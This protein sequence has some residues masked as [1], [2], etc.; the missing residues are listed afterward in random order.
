VAVRVVIATDKFKG[1]ASASQMAEMLA[2]ELEALVPHADVVPLP[3]A[4]GGQGTL[5]ALVGIADEVSFRTVEDAWGDPVDAQVLSVGDEIWVEMSQTAGAGSRSGPAAA[6]TASTYG[7]G[8][9]L[10]RLRDAAHVFVAVGGTLTSDGGAG[11]ATAI[12]WRFV[13]NE[14]EDVARGGRELGR[15]ARIV[16]ANRSA[17]RSLQRAT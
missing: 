17:S 12:G 10:E 15:I 13:D 1:F 14:G 7:T 2:K 5:D 9:L 6:L 3:V 4:D 11:L 8:L 16:P